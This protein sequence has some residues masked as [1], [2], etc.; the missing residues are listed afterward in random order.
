MLLLLLFLSRS[1]MYTLGGLS[2]KKASLIKNGQW[3]SALVGVLKPKRPGLAA[4]KLW[5]AE[6]K[7]RAE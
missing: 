6:M 1:V 7:V 4:Y 2:S 5:W 3:T